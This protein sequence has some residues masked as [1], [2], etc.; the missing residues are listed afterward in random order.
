MNNKTL[1]FI[2]TYNE[3]ENVERIFKEIRTLGLDADI[4][5]LDDNSPDGTGL[6]IDDLVRNNQRL[7]V[8]HRSGETRHRERA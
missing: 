8:I 4:L 1:I 6:I 5:F 3:S 7:F 2:P